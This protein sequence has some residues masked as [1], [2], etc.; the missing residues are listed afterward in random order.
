MADKEQ[1]IMEI[2]AYFPELVEKAELYR[3]QEEIR[4]AYDLNRVKILPKYPSELFDEHY[5]PQLLAET[6]EVGIVARGFFK[7][8]DWNFVGD[9]ITVTIS[10]EEGGVKLMKDARVTTT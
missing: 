5:V 6:E 3:I 8:C 4:N 7:D 1:K 10:Y 9:D 2:T